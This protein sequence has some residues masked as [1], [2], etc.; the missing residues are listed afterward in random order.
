MTTF[1]KTHMKREEALISNS[2][3][4]ISKSLTTFKIT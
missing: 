1:F 4:I 2:K 3:K